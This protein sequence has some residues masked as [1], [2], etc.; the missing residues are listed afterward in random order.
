MSDPQ[1]R[2]TVRSLVPEEPVTN[3]VG[4]LDLHSEGLLLMTNDGDLA[5]VITHPRFQ[6]PKTYHVLTGRRVSPAE[7]AP[8]TD[9][10]E[11]E[12]GRASA[13]S[14]RVI[15]SSGDQSMVELVLTEGRKREIRRMMEQ[16]DVPIST[17]VRT[18]IG[19]IADRTLTP[20]TY[21][22]VTLDEIRALYRYAKE[23]PGD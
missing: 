16:L 17:L 14:A 10:I 23:I 9:G 22:A 3:P 20:G 8:L 11:L 18:G 19:S 6:V 2:P 21:R 13:L 5:H 1:G 4:R 12:D 7:L 15:S